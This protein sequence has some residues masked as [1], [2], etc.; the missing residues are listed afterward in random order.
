MGT[1]TILKRTLVSTALLVVNLFSNQLYSRN[2]VNPEL[3]EN[4][5]TLDAHPGDSTQ[6]NN[7]P[8]DNTSLPIKKALSKIEVDGEL[9]E[10]AW[11]EAG[12]VSD[13]WEKFP[14]SSRRAAKR[15]EVRLLFDKEFIYLSA[16]C[17][18]SGAHIIQS[19]KRDRPFY[20][21]DVFAFII[22][23][24]KKQ[25]MAYYFS[26]TPFNTQSDDM[27]TSNIFDD[28][29][30][31]WDNKWFSATKIYADRW[32]VE[33]AIPFKILKF[34]SKQTTWG[35]NFLRND[36]KANEVHSWV[37]M[38]LQ[39][40]PWDV[41]Y[42]GNLLWNDPLPNS[43][44]NLFINPYT[45]SGL[46]LDKTVTKKAG[47]EMQAGLDF[48]TSLSKSIGVDAT[49]NPD[50][51]QVEIDRQQTNLTRFNLFFPEKRGFFTE[52][53]DIFSAYAGGFIQPFYSRSIGLASDGTALPIYGG[54]KFSGNLNP[55]LRAGV[56]NVI[57]KG[58][59]SNPAQNY[60]AISLH[61]QVLKR[62]LV[63]GYF[64]DRESIG[65]VKENTLQKFGRNAGVEFNYSGVNG[66][67]AGWSGLHHSMKPGIENGRHL[68]QLGGTFNSPKFSAIV[69]FASVGQN[70]YA[71]MG[72]VSRIEN[73]D[74]KYDS[75]FRKG[76]NFYYAKGTYN[77]YPK[78][79]KFNNHKFETSNQFFR[80][81]DG[82]NNDLLNVFRYCLINR[83]S[84]EFRLRFDHQV[85]W[86]QGHTSFTPSVKDE[87]L[88]PGRYQF[89]MTTFYYR[90]DSR[91]KLSYMFQ[92]RDGGF[93]NGRLTQ[94]IGSITYRVQ[95]WGSFALDF[96]YNKVRFPEP[97]GRTSLYLVAPKAEINFSNNLFWTTFIQYNTQRNNLNINSRLQWRY[98]PMSDLFLVYTDNYYTDPFF[99]SKNKAV[100]LKLN[101]WLSK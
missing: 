88:P 6:G 67:W 85:V 50:F 37:P 90:S 82:S 23:P 12:L 11:Q 5:L 4:F 43:G 13:F 71:D 15:T 83:N 14:S 79:T 45:K 28:P 18:D 58:N 64:F 56:L 3:V 66:K 41:G 92:L 36:R 51:S 73:Y 57:T 101:Y 54:I 95:P 65:L 87:P 55:N 76:F 91:K 52:N 25:N 22:D 74:E 86:L 89:F 100:V 35:I 96:E 29:G 59:K 70:Y 1:T 26:V 63:K 9:T 94:S 80:N 21:A 38:P 69:D 31:S 27:L 17:F 93:Y 39:F 30:F 24:Y 84:S 61:Q 2:L 62:S 46:N 40:K 7:L 47:M 97:Y 20:D 42:T 60:S 78:K 75:L 49:V 19:L 44:K 10:A 16:V 34:D 32:V 98:K 68:L 77:V 48:K 99:K 72:F 53:N 8:N 81:H 33:V